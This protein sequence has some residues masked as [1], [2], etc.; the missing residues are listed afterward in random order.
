M[1]KKVNNV[2]SVRNVI[3]V[4]CYIHGMYGHVDIYEKDKCAAIT[5]VKES[6]TFVFMAY[7]HDWDD[8]LNVVCVSDVEGEYESLSNMSGY[9]HCNDDVWD[10]MLEDSTNEEQIKNTID[11]IE[12][13]IDSIF[14]N[15][16]FIEKARKFDEIVK[17]LK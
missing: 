3:Q 16:Q 5:L 2:Q 9:V 1:N 11:C 6:R 14:E 12:L 8:M 4:Q 10:R 13:A 15:A 17:T 7:K